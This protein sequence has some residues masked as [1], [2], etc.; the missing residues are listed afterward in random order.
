MT[1]RLDL[2]VRTVLAA[3]LLV[4]AF[5]ASADAALVLQ[6]KGTGDLITLAEALSI[7]G[8]DLA[9]DTTLDQATIDNFS[10][11][12]Q[13]NFVGCYAVPM[14]DLSTGL[15]V[16]NG[17]DCLRALAAGPDGAQ[18]EAL[19]LFAFTGTGRGAIV[20]LGKTSVRP[21]FEGIGD[22]NGGVT[23]ITG[24]I[25]SGPGGIVGGT[26]SF[27]DATGMARVSGAVTGSIPSG[28]GGIVGGTG[29]FADATGMARVSGAVNLQSFPAVTTFDCAWVLG[30][31]GAGLSLPVPD[32]EVSGKLDE[33]QASSDKTADTVVKIA[34]R[35]S[36]VVD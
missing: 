34:R 12:G 5:S 4:G 33:I 3:A 31:E 28:P 18:L 6:F 11:I 21:F 22:A 30:V 27:A 32:S 20:T 8:V 23:H 7:A 17:I 35:L 25:P 9:T 10:T 24:S 26:G 19:S 36:I 16:G 15:A 14:I 2:A 29:S 1:W 13:N